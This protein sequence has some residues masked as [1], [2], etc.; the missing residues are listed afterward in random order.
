MSKKIKTV[1]AKLIANPGS[2]TVSGRGK[3]LEQVTRSLK[4]MGVKVDVAVAKP[5]EKAIPIARKAVKDGYKVIIAMGGDDTVEAIIRGIAGSKVHLGMIPVGT[6]NNLAKSLGIPEDPEE[7]CALIASGHFRKLDMGQVTVRKGKK[8][9]FFE[10]V[11]IGIVAAVYPDVLHAVKGRLSGIKDAIQTFLSQETKPEVNLIMDGESNI[12]VETM[13]AIVSNVPLI[14]P[15][16]LVDPG[17]STDDGLLDVSLFPSFSKAELLAYSTKVMNEGHTDDGKIQRYRAHKLKIKTS[18]KLEVMADGVMLGK[19]TVRIKVLPGA[20]RVIAPVVGTGVEKS[21]QAAGAD[22]PTPVASVEVNNEPGK[23]GTPQKDGTKS[24]ELIE[25]VQEGIMAKSVKTVQTQTVEAVERPVNFWRGLINRTG[26]IVS[27]PWRRYR[28][29]VFLGY[30][31]IAVIVFIILAVLAKTVAYFTF[32]V[33]ITHAV[34]AFNAGWFGALMYALSWIGF[35]PQAYLIALIVLLFLYMSGLKWETVVGFVSLILST[36]LGLGIKILIDRPR[37]SANL[38]NVISQLKD[39]SF[40]SG[41]VLFFTAFFGFLL[42]LAYTLFKHSW[43]RT[44]LL[45]VLGIM[46]ALI[47]LS[48]IYEGQHWA[49]DVVAAYLLGSVWLSLSIL[50]Y[51]W[52]KPRFFVDQPVAKETPSST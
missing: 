6:A 40:P 34:Q 36:A 21:P 18:P 11:T 46:I 48:R 8:F 23:N 32:D 33:T 25:A 27:K 19:G 31:V 26:A 2:G 15:N 20:L 17:A 24:E 35:T 29:D 42:F 14:G 4:K 52:G 44:L 43:W 22:L 10:L 5:K 1:R 28:A 16:M 41:H 30:M 37:P 45:I 51:R 9:P 12:T 7:A 49:S 50:I 47:G 3:L 13:L 39:Y 38:V